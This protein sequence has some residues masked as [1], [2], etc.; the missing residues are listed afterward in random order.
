[1]SRTLKK[2]QLKQ[3]ESVIDRLNKVAEMLRKELKVKKT[4]RG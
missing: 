4:R 2:Y 1:M 3:I